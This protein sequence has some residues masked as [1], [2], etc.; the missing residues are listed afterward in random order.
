M[1]K[2]VNLTSHPI[3]LRSDDGTREVEIPSSGNV[4][5]ST[6]SIS[7]MDIDG[8]PVR[9]NDDGPPA[10]LPDPEPGVYYIVSWRVL[11]TLRNVRKDILAP[12][13]KDPLWDEGGKIIAVRGFVQ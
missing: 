11:Q 1:M 4:R 6:S 10:G 7:L 9:R 13:T 5:C 2:F 8:W 3:M 12:D